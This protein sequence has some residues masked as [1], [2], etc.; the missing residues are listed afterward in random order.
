M[1][2]QENFFERRAGESELA[3]HKRL[4]EA[5]LVSHTISTPYRELSMYLYGKPY[6]ED[7]ARR[8]AYGEKK[9]F[10]I[11]NAMGEQ[12]EHGSAILE[13]IRKERELLQ[14][15]RQR[16]FDQRREY[17]K[18]LNA[19]GRSKHLY[20]VLEEVAE[21][22]PDSIGRAIKQPDARGELLLSD[23]D[24]VLFFSDWHYGMITDN[25]FNKYN[26]DI[27][28]GRVQKIVEA[29]A[30]RISLHNCDTL[31]IVVLGD[32]I[33]GAIHT[34]ARVA[35]EELVCEQLMQASEILAQAIETLSTYAISTKVY[36]TYG[37]HARTVQNKADNIHRDNFERIIPW[38]LEQ[39]MKGSNNIS[40]T[41]SENEFLFINARGHGIVAAHGDLDNVRSSTRLLPEL[42]RK[43]FGV[44]TE[45]VVL[46]DKHHRESFAELGVTS[47]ICGALCGTDDYA[48]EKRLYSAPEQ[49]LLIVND[50]DGVDAEYHLKA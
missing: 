48:N 39:R 27:A 26:V 38:W 8:M 6:A 34:S 28:I 47:I 10:T 18:I 2:L 30:H 24:A 17:T 32:L 15:E 49:L 40:V 9:V 37:N 21:R 7:V 13:E 19:D 29:A 5:R 20:D 14:Q 3:Y 41:T 33:H 11:L 36:V 31:H 46:G 4:I 25:I 45:Y 22:L 16:Y 1:M 44:D 35:S 43:Q 23:T 12:N 42:F 50:T